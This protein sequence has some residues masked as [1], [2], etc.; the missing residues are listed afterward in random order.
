MTSA[1]LCAALVKLGNEAPFGSGKQINK[2]LSCTPSPI[3]APVRC[4]WWQSKGWLC[5]CTRRERKR[6]K[7]HQEAHFLDTMGKISLQKIINHGCLCVNNKNNKSA[8]SAKWQM[9]VQVSED[10]LWAFQKPVSNVL[11]LSGEGILNDSRMQEPANVGSNECA[12]GQVPPSLPRAV[13]PSVLRVQDRW[14][15]SCT[16]GAASGHSRNSKSPKV[17]ALYP[18]QSVCGGS[19]VFGCAA[20]GCLQ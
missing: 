6:N 16:A 7:V 20:A 13:P 10:E 3:R 5:H 12:W 8:L 9:L 17:S 1:L 15:S 14:S 2:V 18:A 4:Q 19:V 11:L